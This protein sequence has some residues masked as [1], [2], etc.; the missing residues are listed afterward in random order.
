MFSL[1]S[2]GSPRPRSSFI[3]I[4]SS[5][6]AASGS[7]F[8]ADSGSTSRLIN[9]LTLNKKK[10]CIKLPIPHC[11]GRISRLEGGGEVMCGKIQRNIWEKWEAISSYL[12]H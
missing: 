8:A 2:P 9:I 7:I 10:G 3:A 11:W 4:M 6:T 5:L 12:Q 1:Q